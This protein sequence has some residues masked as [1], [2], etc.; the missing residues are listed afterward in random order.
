MEQMEP[1]GMERRQF[2][3]LL[4]LGAAAAVI[5][6]ASRGAALRKRKK[7]KKVFRL[8]V[9]KRRC[10]NA[11]KG[12]AANRFYR[13]KRA[14]NKDRAHPGCNCPIV[15]QVIDRELAKQYFK[16]RK[17]VHDLREVRV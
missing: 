14:A 9:H 17:K 4:A 12:H 11:C 10:C 8:S 5:P 3:R 6:T 13:S 2:L 16:G 7:T 15:T 1:G